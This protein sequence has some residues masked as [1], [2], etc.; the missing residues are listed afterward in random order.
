MIDDKPQTYKGLYAM[1]KY[2][3][4]KPHNLVL[5]YISRFSNSGDIVLDPF[6]G[7]GVTIIESLRNGRKAIGLDI[8][9]IAIFITRMSLTHIDIKKLKESYNKLKHDILLLINSMYQTTCPY[10][11]NQNGYAT[12]YIWEHDSIKEI[13]LEC[14]ECNI[15]KIIKNP[16]ERDALLAKNIGLPN[17]WYPDVLLVENSRIN[18]KKGMKTLDLFTN[19]ALNGLSII[20][21]EIEKIEDASIRETLR[22]C[23]S[24]MLPQSS[25][26]VFVI[27]RRGKTKKIDYE[28]KAEVG[29]W[30]IGY[31]I[32]SEHFEI[33][34]WRCFENRFKRIIRG[35]EDILKTVPKDLNTAQ[36]L[37]ELIIED[38]GYFLEVTSATKMMIESNTV[39]YVFT[40]PP[41]GNRIPYMELS[42]M[43]NS[44]LKFDVD[45]D[46]E[47]II[48]EA[49]TRHKNITQYNRNLILAIG[50]IWRVLKPN[51]FM[52]IA[53]NSL[54]DATWFSL[55]SACFSIGF[56][57]EEI[58]P[59]EYSARSVVQDTRKNA[60][61]TDLVI[62][63]QKTI[64]P[65][66]FQFLD[67]DDLIKI[68]ELICKCIQDNKYSHTYDILN[69]VII[70]RARDGYFVKISKILDILN[71]KFIYK[72][73]YWQLKR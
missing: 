15:S 71:D 17:L 21:S 27:R 26:M 38:K 57:L 52:S 47:I 34:V 1:H 33:N 10:C 49:K 9:P 54:D 19:R 29:S 43:W 39:D 42:L 40:D 44:W 18:A 48:S 31:W 20:L 55:M 2:W 28:S 62:T 56:T 23:F 25:R 64:S 63:F 59:L 36:S 16:D 22:F 30:V 24:A 12:H 50:E 14:S 37:S 67:I 53:F 3:S 68:E 45:W 60:L 70:A 73:P 4:R 66:T 6:C 41:H 69:Y 7:S 32:P 51:K 61:K 8:N 58:K 65:Q 13:W 35:I 72:N 5:D 46:K 11:G